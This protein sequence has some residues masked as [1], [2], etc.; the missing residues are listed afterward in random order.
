MSLLQSDDYFNK[1]IDDMKSKLRVRDSAIHTLEGIPKFVFI[2]GKQIINDTTGKI[3]DED[4]LLK[5]ENKRYAIMNDLIEYKTPVVGF[6]GDRNVVL[7]IISE[8]LYDPVSHA[9]TDMLTFEGIL[10]NLSDDIILIVESDGTKCELGAF[11]S[12]PNLA[13]K[14]CIINDCNYEDKPSFIARGPIRKVNEISQKII[15]V[16]FSSLKAF[17][18]NRALMNCL[19]NIKKKKVVYKS[20][21]DEE[22]ID[23]KNLIY[24]LMAILEVFEPLTENE[25]V[26]LYKD[27][28]NIQRYNI[29]NN[30]RKRFPNIE[31][32]LKFMERINLLKYKN[33]YYYFSKDYNFLCVNTLFN[34]KETDF[35]VIRDDYRELLKLKHPD[36]LGVIMC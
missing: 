14:L 11:A 24:E 32:V 31:S 12:D 6:S 30:Y 20:N 28:K 16:D 2:C 21:N 25:I 34:I 3:I 8:L 23:V 1:L 13:K 15:Y 5:D 10:C 22:D 19:D 7:P 33:G 27:I 9:L 26:W 18:E 4:I 29:L 35:K 36:R 17:K